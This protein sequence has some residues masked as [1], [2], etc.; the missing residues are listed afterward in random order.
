MSDILRTFI[1]DYNK[2]P[3]SYSFLNV[4]EFNDIKKFVMKMDNNTIDYFL[5]NRNINTEIWLKILDEIKLKN[6]YH[7][8]KK[9]IFFK[10]NRKYYFLELIKKY[11]INI[12]NK[13]INIL[14]DKDE[15]FIFKI[16]NKTENLLQKLKKDYNYCIKN[17]LEGY[18]FLK[19]LS[20]EDRNNFIK[21]MN[22]DTIKY[23]LENRQ[24]YYSDWI[25]ILS[26]IELDNKYYI[27]RKSYLGEND[28]ILTINPKKTNLLS[29]F[30]FFECKK[31]KEGGFLSFFSKENYII[32]LLIENNKVSLIDNFK[33]SYWTNFSYTP[34]DSENII[35]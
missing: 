14:I 27:Y 12:S 18:S 30:R 16:K 5:K 34:D 11:E 32:N 24:I 31:N 28:G 2:E 29:L 9:N 33:I 15:I 1:E 25:N 19:V 20:K 4:L 8:Y 22:I 17:N 35:R 7:I 26:S 6:N 10:R 13:I 3:E 21:N 23:C